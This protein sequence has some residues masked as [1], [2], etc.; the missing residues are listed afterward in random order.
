MVGSKSSDSTNM[1]S[2][3]THSPSKRPTK[4]LKVVHLISAFHLGGAELVAYRLAR[5]VKHLD[6]EAGQMVTYSHHLA[7][8]MGAEGD[9]SDE[10]RQACEA[11]GIQVHELSDSTSEPGKKIAARTSWLRLPFL[12]KSL[13]ADV[14]HCHTDLPDFNLAMAWHAWPLLAPISSFITG[15]V[16]TRPAQVRTI[17]NTV[18]WPTNGTAAWLTERAFKK[19]EVVAISEPARQA[20]LQLK[21]RVGMKPTDN[22]VVIP[23]PMPLEQA[24][25][26]EVGSTKSGTQQSLRFL[27]CGRLCHQKGFDLLVEAMK[28]L[29]DRG[30]RCSLTIV[31]GG[32]MAH[33]IPTLQDLP[34]EVNYLPA[35]FD[36]QDLL[37]SHDLLLMPSR[38]EGAPLLVA[39]AILVGLPV[40]GSAVPGIAQ[41]LPASWPLLLPQDLTTATLADAMETA[42]AQ[43]EMVK[44][45]VALLVGK[46]QE[47]L[48]QQA[49]TTQA[50]AEAYHRAFERQCG[51]INWEV[52]AA[53][54]QAT[55]E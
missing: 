37:H 47:L 28:R 15:S 51:A 41:Q 14:V 19:D 12:L 54:A 25:P 23:N 49:L 13:K 43:P 40:L 30:K 50:Y 21:Q 38:F 17:H 10:F 26:V 3:A 5:L 52:Q 2:S 6:L 20:Y 27:F 45:S 29:A 18:L 1:T 4:Q 39:E 48:A 31:G 7:A 32:E 16:Q 24:G 8:I 22:L 53:M 9:Y 11:H 36:I 55:E 34:H 33:L 44:Q 46:R 35:R 42:L